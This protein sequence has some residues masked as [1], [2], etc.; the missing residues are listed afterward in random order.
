MLALARNRS[1][2]SE[3]VDV[4]N[5]RFLAEELHRLR[6][7]GLLGQ[8]LISRPGVQAP[9]FAATVDAVLAVGRRDAVQ[10]QMITWRLTQALEQHGIRALPLKG[11][12]LAERLH[13]DAGLRLSA[14]IDILVTSADLQ[15]AVG[16]LEE[17]GCRRVRRGDS[18]PRLHHI[19]ET[20]DGIPVELHWRIHWY[21]TRV[22]RAHAGA[23][24][25]RG[26]GTAA[27]GHG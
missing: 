9:E 3:L 23:F 10:K 6:V 26:R 4:A 2:L 27:A 17:A 8:R 12:F 14:D 18:L 25:V 5:L 21:E 20:P 15:A 11:A 7:L 13:Q 22:R 1:N 16:V 24:G 19:L